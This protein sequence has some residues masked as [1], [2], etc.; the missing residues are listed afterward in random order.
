LDQQPCGL[1]YRLQTPEVP[2]SSTQVR[3]MIRTGVER[4]PVPEP[5]AHY[6][7]TH[8]LYQDTE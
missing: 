2:V 7:Q 1:A 4:L 8:A 6:I 5:I 3:A